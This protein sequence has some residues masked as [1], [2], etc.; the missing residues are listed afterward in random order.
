[1]LS[2]FSAPDDEPVG[3][4]T[5]NVSCVFNDDTSSREGFKLTSQLCVLQCSSSMTGLS[6]ACGLSSAIREFPG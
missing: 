2:V 3:M 5:P 1:M 6:V 4:S